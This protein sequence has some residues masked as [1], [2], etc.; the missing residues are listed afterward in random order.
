M[1]TFGMQTLGKI[2]GVMT[3]DRAME[4]VVAS[5]YIDF[6]EACLDDSKVSVNDWSNLGMATVRIVLKKHVNMTMRSTNGNGYRCLAKGLVLYGGTTLGTIPSTIDG[7]YAANYTN[8]RNADWSEN[9]TSLTINYLAIPCGKAAALANSSISGRAYVMVVREMPTSFAQTYPS[10]RLYKTNGQLTFD[11]QLMPVN[12]RY[13]LP[14]PSG[15]N[16]ANYRT[17]SSL[18]KGSMVSGTKMCS[19]AAIHTGQAWAGTSNYTVRVGFQ[20]STNGTRYNVRPTGYTRNIFSDYVSGSYGS[21]APVGKAIYK[22]LLASDY[23]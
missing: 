16:Y 20:F 22:V 17:L 6:N 4:V 19:M 11:S 7:R 18:N 1:A 14:V 10:I 5:G 21:S 13:Y 23:F 9:S 15:Y 12:A 8:K 3:S 2:E